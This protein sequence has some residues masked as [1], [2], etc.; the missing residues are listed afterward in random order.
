MKYMKHLSKI[1]ALILLLPNLAAANNYRS[2]SII[3]ISSTAQGLMIM[4]DSPVPDNCQG[5]PYNWLLIPEQNK[6]M[7]SLTMAL[8]LSGKKSFTVYTAN[9]ASGYCEVI[10]V[11]PNQ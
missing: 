7:I 9:R 6:T 1:M 4:L 11:H 5:T 8:W 3:N 2:G 10:Q